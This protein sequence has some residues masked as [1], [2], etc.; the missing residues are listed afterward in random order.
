MKISVLLNTHGNIPIIKDSIDSIRT[1]MSNDILLIVDGANWKEVRDVNLGVH[2]VEGF[3]HNCPKAPFR[4][5]A[6][7]M[8]LLYNKWSDSD[9]YCYI[10]YDTLVVSSYFKTSLE[11]AIEKNVWFLGNDG[12]VSPQITIPGLDSMIGV[13]IPKTAY[14]YMLGCCQFFHHHFMEKL[15]DR[16]FFN[17]FLLYTNDF[18]KGDY[19]GYFGY[20]VSEHMYPTLARAL[21]GNIGVFA[22]WNK[23]N[24]EWHGNY[25]RYP[26]RWQ[27]VI[28]EEEN[29]PEA[30]LIHPLKSMDH[31]LRQ[32]YKG[33]RENE[34][35]NFGDNN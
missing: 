34:K 13:H 31:P 15:V 4:N 29:Y 30:T 21:G 18:T 32:F 2:K 25:T 10:E 23:E 9:W 24:S 28:G 35:R 17:N 7:G 27:P 5:I 22:S 6:L 1:Y 33:L 20:D 26:M 14:Y 19:P 3:Y 16:D 12:R 11:K 8:N